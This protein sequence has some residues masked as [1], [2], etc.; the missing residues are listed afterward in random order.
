MS[1]EFLAVD[2]DAA[3][4]RL[5]VVALRDLGQVTVVATKV[6][7]L[8]LLDARDF[9]LVITDLSLPGPDYGFVDELV[10]RGMATIVVTAYAMPKQLEAINAAAKVIT[11]PFRPPSCESWCRIR[12]APEEASL[13]SS[14][15]PSP[16]TSRSEC[17]LRPAFQGG[18][19]RRRF[20]S[21]PTGC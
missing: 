18:R 13:A 2:D 1:T 3:M 16:E 20:E 9:D 4:R 8:R 15:P 10:E 17:P 7:A 6:E 19:E 11:K 5:L 14:V 21:Y 12:S